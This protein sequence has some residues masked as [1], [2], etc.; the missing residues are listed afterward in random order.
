MSPNTI[1]NYK[2]A[3]DR[4]HAGMEKF[5]F[6]LASVG[7]DEVGKLLAWLRDEGRS[8]TRKGESGRLLAPTLALT[9]VAWRMY[10]RFCAAEKLIARDRIQLADMPTVWKELP[11]ALSVAEVEALLASVPDTPMRLRDRA[12]LELLYACGGRASEVAGLGLA[13]LRE[14]MTLVRLCGKGNKERVVPL[15]GKARAAVRR[16]LDDL[17]PTLDPQSRLDFIII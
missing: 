7:P 10:S 13:D 9:L 6:D 1:R 17:R 14:G 16:Y 4:L 8:G 12:A 15:G 2:L 3:L 11:E 5:G